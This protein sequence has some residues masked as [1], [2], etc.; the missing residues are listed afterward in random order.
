MPFSFDPVIYTGQRLQSLYDV[1][2]GHLADAK[3]GISALTSTYLVCV[4]ERLVK[5][6]EEGRK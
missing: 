3:A 6:E 1:A 4:A 2:S 5:N